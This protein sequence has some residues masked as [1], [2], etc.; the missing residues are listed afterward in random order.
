MIRVVQSE[1]ADTPHAA[2]LRPVSS[3]WDPVTPATRRLELAAGPELI[4]VCRR[5]GELPLGS[6]V[7]THAGALSHAEWMVHVIVRSTLEPVTTDTV[8]RGLQNGLRRIAQLGIE[9]V[10]VAPLGTGAGNLDAEESARE[11]VP[12]LLEHLQEA[13]YPEVV[14]IVVDSDYE[15]QAFERQ[16]KMFDLPFLP[17]TE[18]EPAGSGLRGESGA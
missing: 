4:E 7:I 13:R 9:S 5:M 16:L 17:D 12:V 14:E 6:A 1:L 15:Q 3:E 11:M 10:A 8:R 18:A 2:V